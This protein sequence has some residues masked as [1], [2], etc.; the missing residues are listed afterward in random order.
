[1]GGLLLVN[2]RVFTMVETQ[3][4]AEAVA[5][6]GGLIV[7]AGAEAA[8]RRAAPAEA[9]VVDCGGRTVIPGIIDAH[10]HLLAWAAA[11]AAVDCSDARSIDD[12]VALLRERAQA[13]PPG[14]WVRAA[15]YDEFALSERRHP[16]RWDL[17]RATSAHPVRLLHRSGHALVLNSFGL[18][19]AGITIASEEP[20]G[21][22]ID[23]Q[24]DG[25]EPSGLLLEMEDTVARAVPPLPPTDLVAGL[26]VANGRLLAAGVTSV[27]DLTHTNDGAS[28]RLLTELT[29]AA[30]FAPYWQA[31]DGWPGDASRLGRSAATPVKLMVREAGGSMTPDEPALAQI[32]A[33]CAGRGRPVAVHAAARRTVDAVIRAFERAGV[34]GPAHRIEH[35]G[36]C[37]PGTAA[38]I[39]ALGLTVV[40]NPAFLWYSGD[41]YLATVSQAELPY[42]YDAAGLLAAG[43]PVAAGSDAPV[44]QPAP[45]AAISAAVRR[46]SRS[47]AQMPGH[48]LSPQAALAMHTSAAAA[49]TG[50]QARAG[51]IAPGM[52]ADLVVIDGEPGIA[53]TSPAA[54]ILGGRVCW[55]DGTAVAAEGAG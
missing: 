52:R 39:G 28:L 2:A 37:P 55:S 44:T 51:R 6:R 38:R 8:C 14:N 54:T 19:Q 42:L 34:S 16:T 21:G 22:V 35:A 41:R 49:A 20:P 33:A 30:G 4:I 24:L 5:I 26:R 47:G 12:I 17:D 32:I 7:A 25:G 45:L 40:S 1:M 13:L 36:I 10:V 29:E 50:Q 18:A 15:G 48:G 9:R 43:V 46:R 27:M 11:L 23:R 31:A 3:P 53:T